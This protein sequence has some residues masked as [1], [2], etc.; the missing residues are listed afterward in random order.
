MLTETDALWI[1]YPPFPS[2]ATVYIDS[3]WAIQRGK[4]GEVEKL[5]KEIED[6]VAH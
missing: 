5:L 4:S 6:S 3:T 1:E 2:I